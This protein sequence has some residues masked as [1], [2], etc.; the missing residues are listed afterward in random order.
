[1]RNLDKRSPLP[2]LIYQ[3]PAHAES[4]LSMKLFAH[5]YVIMTEEG[6]LTRTDPLIAV[7]TPLVHPGFA[8]DRRLSC[9]T[10]LLFC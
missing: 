2:A 8:M 5:M 9:L 1:M 4:D 3:Q 6:D 10:D 7:G